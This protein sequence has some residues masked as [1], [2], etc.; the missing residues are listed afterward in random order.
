MTIARVRVVPVG[1]PSRGNPAGRR[2]VGLGH[3]FVA[4][5]PSLFA[6]YA[7]RGTHGPSG[8]CES[9]RLAEGLHSDD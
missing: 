8:A 6:P 4:T 9:P 5:R 3:R 2:P 1:A 7:G